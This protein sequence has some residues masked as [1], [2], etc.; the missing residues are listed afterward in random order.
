MVGGLGA[1]VLAAYVAMTVPLLSVTVRRVH[2]AGR[3]TWW[4]TG[5]LLLYALAVGAALASNFVQSL[6]GADGYKVTDFLTLT[7]IGCVVGYAV[8]GCLVLG[9]V[10]APSTAR[11]TRWDDGYRPA[12]LLDG[13]Y[14]TQE[15]AV[16]QPAVAVAACEGASQDVAAAL[17]PT[18]PA[19]QDVAA[20][21]APYLSPA[22]RRSPAAAPKQAAQT[23]LPDAYRLASGSIVVPVPA[24][25]LTGVSATSMEVPPGDEAFT[26]W[27]DYLASRGQ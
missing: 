19:S 21:L 11:P 7:I 24:D 10:L 17:P 2:D 26:L 16:G 6:D 8:L 4:V 18:Q 1:L 27:S 14:A 23:P 22:A 13:Y 20:A 15:R 9:W 5:V 12:A 25:P 3:S